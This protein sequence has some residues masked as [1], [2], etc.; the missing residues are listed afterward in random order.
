MLL[1]VRVNMWPTSKG[2]TKTPTKVNWTESFIG[3]S[4]GMRLHLGR[5]NI[6][7]YFMVSLEC[8]TVMGL[9]GTD[10]EYSEEPMLTVS[11]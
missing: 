3:E 10:G 11:I 4:R 1:S 7:N 9:G 8:V 2:T 6:T 5:G